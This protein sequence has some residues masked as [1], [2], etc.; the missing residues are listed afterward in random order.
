MAPPAGH[1]TANLPQNE[2]ICFAEA[3][4]RQVVTENDSKTLIF[5]LQ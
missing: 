4:E 3:N 1:S 5:I 2:E